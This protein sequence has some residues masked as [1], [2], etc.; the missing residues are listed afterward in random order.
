MRIINNYETAIKIEDGKYA[1]VYTF[2]NMQKKLKQL[3]E[4]NQKLKTEIE[5]IKL[6][7]IMRA[8]KLNRN[9]KQTADKYS[10]KYYKNCIEW[11]KTFAELTEKIDNLQKGNK[12]LVFYKERTKYWRKS[13]NQVLGERN[14][15]AKKVRIYR[16]LLKHG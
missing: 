6:D 7:Y 11:C 10:D 12:D 5:K 9:Y 16:R 1:D 2:K 4:E 8:V 14:E 15:L 13:W 3:E